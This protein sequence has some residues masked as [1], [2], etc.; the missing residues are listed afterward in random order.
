MPDTTTTTTAPDAASVTTTT[1]APDALDAQ[2]ETQETFDRAYV[3]KLRKEAA[4]YRERA[5]AAQDAADAQKKAAERSKLDEVERLK[6]EIT[7]R[8]AALAQAKQEALAARRLATLTG[9]VADP[10]AALKL[11]EDAHVQEDG[12]INLDAFL[13]AYPFLSPKTGP[14]SINPTNAASAGKALT[15]ADVRR[16]TPAEINDRWDEIKNLKG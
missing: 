6:A 13:Q 5:K 9:K 1:Q 7:D 16:M 3:E 12:S 10:N 8:D 14:A 11:L 2:A 4:T 15:M